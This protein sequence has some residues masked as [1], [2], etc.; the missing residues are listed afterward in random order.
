VLIM[1]RHVAGVVSE[2]DLLAIEDKRARGERSGQGSLLHRRSRKRTWGHTAGELMTSPAITIHADA[3]I[4]AAAR[5]LNQHHIKRLP[6]VDADGILIGIVSRR[7]LLSVFLRSDEDIAADIRRVFTDILFADPDSVTVAVRGGIVTVTGR[8]GQQE[9]PDL[10]PVAIRLTWD[11][12]GVV[13][14][15]DKLAAD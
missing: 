15:V 6:V 4:P 9:Q 11:I 2:A 7:D 1:G 5:V 14:V 3:T 13:D 8:A 10:I 12:D